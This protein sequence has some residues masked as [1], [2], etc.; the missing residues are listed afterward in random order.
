MTTPWAI[1][2]W[3]EAEPTHGLMFT[4]EGGK[5]LELYQLKMAG[6]GFLNGSKDAKGWQATGRQDTEDDAIYIFRKYI[7]Q[8]EKADLLDFAETL[9]A[10]VRRI[11]L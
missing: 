6:K 10:L 8:T 3:C 11:P 7:G 9:A 4:L 5:Y 2:F 1:E